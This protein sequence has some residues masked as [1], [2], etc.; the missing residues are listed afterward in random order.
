MWAAQ[1]LL[2]GGDLEEQHWRNADDLYGGTIDDIEDINV[3]WETFEIAYQG[4]RPLV[5]PTWMSQTYTLL[6]Q[7]I[8]ML[9]HHQMQMKDLDDLRFNKVPYRQFNRKGE[10]I[11]SNIMS[12]DWVWKQCDI[13]AEDATNHGAMFVPFV[14]GSDRTTVSVATGHHEYHPV[15]ASPC[16]FTNVTRQSHPFALCPIAFLVIP[17]TT[18]SQQ[19]KL[20]LHAAMLTPEAIMCPDGHYRCVI[21]GLGPYISDYPEQVYLAGIVSGWCPKCMNRPEDLDAQNARPHTRTKTEFLITCF[22]PGIVWDEY[23]TWSD[24]VV[25]YGNV[26]A[27]YELTDIHELLMP[28][29]LHQMIKGI[30]KDH[31]VEW[32]TEYINGTRSPTRAL[33]IL[34]DIDRRV[35]AA[36]PFPG[37][38]RF[39]DGRD[40]N[41]WTGDDSKALMKV[42]LAAITGYVPSD[43]IKAMSSF[44]DFCYIT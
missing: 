2:S 38:R 12:A 13:L 42:Y 20:P 24:V 35:N 4:P 33:E 44:L 30:F 14:G 23:G 15:Y 27:N 26:D 37:L 10:R 34:K 8:R 32:V 28:D 6:V 43:M 36:P 41:Q 17:K 3:P 5:P 22:D 29:L 11:C 16:N 9:F 1:T 19:K 7:D 39:P 31:L 18:K 40:F 25:S 21:Y